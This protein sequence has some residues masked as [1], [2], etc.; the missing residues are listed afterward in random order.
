MATAVVGGTTYVFA[1]G[2]F[3]GASAYSRSDTTGHLVNMDNES[4][5]R[6][7]VGL[8]VEAVTVGGNTY[9]IS[10]GN[11]ADGLSVFSV[12]RT[13]TSHEVFYIAD[14]TNIALDSPVWLKTKVLGGVTYLFV[15]SNGDTNDAGAHY[16]AVSVWTVNAD[17]SLT[18][19]ANVYDNDTTQMA[20]ISS[21][22]SG[23][24]TARRI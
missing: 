1:S 8:Q 18:N 24:T 11:N 3:D 12:A 14:D 7:Y 5:G 4:G 9:L 10:C 13:A 21:L 20:L 15:A 17:G 22:A 19:V 23:M 16:G 2:Y 6:H